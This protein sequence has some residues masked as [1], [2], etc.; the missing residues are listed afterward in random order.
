MTNEKRLRDA[1]VA[2][3]Q[4]SKSQYVFAAELANEVAALRETVHGL[5]P[6]FG[7]VFEKRRKQA[8]QAMSASVEATIAQ[9][10]SLIRKL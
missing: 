10:D 1:L 9:F 5:D 3:A 4:I 2:L 7:D 8:A 6:T